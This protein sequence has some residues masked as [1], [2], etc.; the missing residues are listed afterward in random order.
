[1]KNIVMLLIVV[2][3][4]GGGAF[5]AL[6]KK[7][8]VDTP[9]AMTATATPGMVLDDMK[10]S[11]AKVVENGSYLDYSEAAFAQSAG[12]KRVYF[13][14][15]NW[16]PTCKASNIEFNKRLSEIPKDVVIFKTD[17]DTQSALKKKYAITYQH[18]FV[19]VDASGKELAKWNGGD[20][21]AL[22]SHLK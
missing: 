17:Y 21:D 22:V 10:K 3:I 13:F 11:D 19:Q 5:I 8:T 18:T 1:M 14:H 2:A 6:S 4:I 20:I 7:D 12:K 9:E 16:C 15:A